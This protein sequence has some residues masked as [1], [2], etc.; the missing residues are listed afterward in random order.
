MT[1]SLLFG[2]L[3]NLTLSWW[4]VPRSTGV[5]VYSP[6]Q[7]SG[8]SHSPVAQEHTISIAP[9]LRNTLTL[10]MSSSATLLTVD[11]DT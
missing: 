4:D 9:S 2:T 3:K 1:S 5:L 10:N 7:R 11:D 8:L 6:T